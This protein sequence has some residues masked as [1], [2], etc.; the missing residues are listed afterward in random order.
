MTDCIRLS[1]YTVG[2]ILQEQGTNRKCRIRRIT[3][4]NG[5]VVF[6]VAFLDGEIRRIFVRDKDILAD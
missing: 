4:V 1:D 3:Q 6:L 2:G 5:F